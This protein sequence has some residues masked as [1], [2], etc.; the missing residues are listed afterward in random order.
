MNPKSVVLIVAA[1]VAVA[2]LAQRTKADD[3]FLGTLN[4]LLRGLIEQKIVAELAEHD[5]EQTSWYKAKSKDKQQWMKANLFG[6]HV[7]VRLASWTEESKTWLWLEDPEKKLTVELREFS[8]SDGRVAFSLTADAKMHFKA[9]GHIPRLGQA[10]AG[11]TTW[12]KI[13]I[14]GSAAVG[15]GRLEKA[16]VTT[17]KGEIRDLQFN[18]H[19]A[20]PAD[21][22]VKDWLNAHVRNDNDHLREKLEKAINRVRF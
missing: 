11:G 5:S 20:S 9:W 22:L 7:K 12:L 1:L 8:V 19:L 10:S 14:A 6:R 17:L 15:A 4:P 21:N 18:N 16:E 3:T 13:E 2:S